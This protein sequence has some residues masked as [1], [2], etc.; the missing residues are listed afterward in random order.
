MPV[1]PSEPGASLWSP[2]LVRG[3]VTLHLCPWTPATSPRS[4]HVRLQHEAALP[5]CSLCTRKVIGPE[6]D[7]QAPQRLQE[8]FP[9]EVAGRPLRPS[10]RPAALLFP[11]GV[12]AWLFVAALH[13]P[14]KY[15][16]DSKTG[17]RFPAGPSQSWR[18]FQC[19]SLTVT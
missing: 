1:L 15:D 5:R 19:L 2:R 14:G 8:E 18:K 12:Y 10:L 17:I 16:G 13:I 11:S 3:E 7:A 9:V 6:E 4:R